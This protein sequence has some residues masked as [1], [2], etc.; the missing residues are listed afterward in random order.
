MA[1][2]IGRVIFWFAGFASLV[3]ILYL[4]F[5]EG[6]T[7][8][9]GPD[10]YFHLHL[11]YLLTKGQFPFRDF[12]TIYSP[13]FH[14]TLIP[15]FNS[16]GESFVALTASRFLIFGYTILTLIFTFGIGLL[17]SN[18]YTAFTAVIV[19]AALP[20][21][22]E[23]AIEVR[24]DNLMIPLCLGGVFFALL[25]LKKGKKSAYFLSGLFFGL[26]FLTLIKIAIT[27]GAFLL[28]LV[29][30]LFSNKLRKEIY[31]GLVWIFLGGLLPLFLFSLLLLSKGVLREGW[32]SIL[33]LSKDSLSILRYGY[34]LNPFFWFMPND[35]VYGTFRGLAW[36]VN[37]LILILAAIGVTGLIIG[38]PS[39]LRFWRLNR[40]AKKDEFNLRLLLLL[41]AVVSFA[42][43]FLV[44]RPFHQY[45]LPFLAFVPFW[46]AFGAETI[47]GKRKN[48]TVITFIIIITVIALSMNDS[49]SVKKYWT[50][51]KDRSFINFVL[52]KT[53]QED[54]FW[55]GD[56]E[57]VFRPDGY[58]VFSARFLEMPDRIKKTLPPFPQMLEIRKTKYLLENLEKLKKN[59]SI[60][61]KDQKEYRDWVLANFEESGYPNLLVRK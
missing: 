29:P 5:R 21:A 16:I 10:E 13:F 60:L 50:D 9:F 36:Q 48:I 8:S 56:G 20:S 47:G 14:M 12:F 15:I 31:S 24:P 41:P 19:T 46:A 42:Y 32:Y 61:E 4:R 34:E 54:V 57:Y 3:F 22:I 38:S 53:K 51:E 28:G 17:V 35:A 30:L 6:I 59:N 58:F 37:N 2:K 11:T 25:G 49:W 26:S 33:L 44:P 52:S 18:I 45:I 40:Q 27:V 7:R 55:G 1:T 23:K 43:L 39:S